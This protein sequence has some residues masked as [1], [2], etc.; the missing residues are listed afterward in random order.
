M[1]FNYLDDEITSNHDYLTT[2]STIKSSSSKDLD[3]EAINPV[4]NFSEEMLVIPKLMIPKF[5]LLNTIPILSKTTTNDFSIKTNDDLTD[6]PLVLQNTLDNQQLKNTK[7]SVKM[8]QLYMEVKS[9]FEGKRGNDLVLKLL[10]MAGLHK[11]KEIDLLSNTL[12]MA[13]EWR[14]LLSFS[15]RRNMRRKAVAQFSLLDY[16][17][18]ACSE[19]ELIEMAKLVETEYKDTK[20]YGTADKARAV[21]LYLAKKQRRKSAD[22]IRYGFRRALANTRERAHGKFVKKAHVDIRLVATQLKG[23]A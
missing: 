12:V 2:M 22:Y 1:E 5:S 21:S 17:K 11:F 4:Y 6:K 13:N 23:T 16:I 7:E 15:E 3:F 20:I 19:A 9:R 8:L 18:V 10:D 14:N